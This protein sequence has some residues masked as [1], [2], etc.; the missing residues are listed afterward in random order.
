[1]IFAFRIQIRAAREYALDLEPN[2][3]CK[4]DYLMGNN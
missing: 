4:Q 3:G 1:M 2:K